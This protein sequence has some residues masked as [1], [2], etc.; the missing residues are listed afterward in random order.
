MTI[1]R[2]VLNRAGVFNFWFY[3][4][5]VFELSDG[6]LIFRGANGSGKSV[7]MQS[8]LPLVLDGDKRPSRLDP[9]GSRDRK[10]EYY[11]L[12]EMESGINDRTGYLYLEFIQPDSGK[13]V[14]IGIGLRARRGAAQV[15]FWGFAVTDQRRIGKDL[16]LYDTDL[17]EK[18][19]KKVPLDRTELEAV[20]GEGG[21]VVREQGEYRQLVNQLLFGFED[22]EAYKDLL[23]LL[24]Q[25]RSPKLSKEF[26]PSTIYGILNEAL[27]PL[28]EEDLRPLSEVLE[29]MDEIGDRL[30]ELRLHRAE[31][32]KLEATYN[33][34]NELRLYELSAR[35]TDDAR[36]R[37]EK[38]LGVREQENEW[39][40]LKG[41]VEQTNSLLSNSKQELT[42]KET[43]ADYLNRSE[44]MEKQQ[45]LQTVEERLNEAQNEI[46]RSDSRLK[47]NEEEIGRK[48]KR[49]KDAQEQ[50][51][52][53]QR[54]QDA[55]RNELESLSKEMEFKDHFIYE[56]QWLDD[57][58]PEDERLWN[59]WKRDVADY[60]LRLKEVHVL[61]VRERESAAR[62][63]EVEENMSAA[64]EK[65]D[66]VERDMQAKEEA[67][68]QTIL[69]QEDALLAWFK[70]LQ[71]L[72]LSE[73]AWR[74]MIHRLHQYP[75]LDYDE[76]AAPV[77]E[78]WENA[79]SAATTKRLQVEHERKLLTEDRDQ[80]KA[81]W[82]EWKRY[83]EPEPERTEAR[84]RS[85]RRRKEVAGESC[86]GAPLYTC[87]EFR[88]HVDEAIKAILESV[89]QR[90]G[91]LDAWISPTA[92]SV[93]EQ[94]EEMWLNPAPV[95]FGHTLVDYLE[96]VVPEGSGLTIQQIEDILR[97]V[98]IGD[99][100][101]GG[102]YINEHGR[103]VLGPLTGQ[104]ASKPRAEWIGVETRK[105]TRLAE[106]QR[107]EE[108]IAE[109]ER[110][111]AGLNESWAALVY[112]IEQ[113][114]L[115]RDALPS[116]E[117]LRA[118]EKA[119]RHAHAELEHARQV[120][121]NLSEKY[122]DAVRQWRELQRSLLESTAEWTRLKKEK[123]FQEAL[124]C[125]QEYE[126][127]GLELKSSFTISGRIQMEAQLLL[128]EI[129]LLTERAQ[130]EEENLQQF[131]LREREFIAAVE[132]L[133]ALVQ[134][135]GAL[136]I[137]RQLQQLKKECNELKQTIEQCNTQLRRLDAELGASAER[138]TQRKSALD[139][140]EEKLR[141]SV[142]RLQR[143]WKWKLVELTSDPSLQSV[144]METH[145]VVIRTAHTVRGLY[146]ARYDSRRKEQVMTHL[147]E[148]FALAKNA[149]LEY[150]LEQ[151]Y[152]EE[153][154][155][156][157]IESLRDRNQP[158]TPYM[159]LRELTRMEEEQGLLIDEKDK[160][161]YEQILIHS[162]GRAIKDKI[163][164]AE[165]W[166][167]IMNRFMEERKT[168]SGLILSLEWTPRAARNERELD[169]EKL[170]RL[171]R[172]DPS[173]LLDE[174]L[175]QMVEHFRSRIRWAK[176]D[177]EEGDS[178]RK[179]IQEL[180]DYRGWFTFTLYYR[181]GSQPRRE[182]TDSRFNVLSGGEKAMAMYIP[183]FA[184]TDSRY[185]DSRETA[186][187]MIS[188]DE[189][190]AGVDDENMR[191]MFGLLT[192]MK[193][194]YMMTSQV[195]WGCYD[196]V[197]SLSIYEIYRPLD[198]DFVTLIPYYWNG[199][200]RKMLDDGEWSTIKEVA[201]SK[202]E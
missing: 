3:T 24:I 21:K 151:R 59:S 186:P 25:L 97:T 85:R 135:M 165:Q 56:R 50:L 109:I 10:I 18:Q 30:E 92:M 96:P 146:R 160:E 7:T 161:L 71:W 118:A 129:D 190:F 55:L 79:L 148:T 201:A 78:A 41:E 17:F 173:T 137:H 134:E 114:K 167:A 90:S 101:E 94:E 187:R 70:R 156:I 1:Q 122:K 81:Q 83:R 177:A 82:E 60:R 112:H 95:W 105:Q 13:V 171:L 184:A 197:P 5:E 179:W 108:A 62:A 130:I 63:R 37:E 103:F 121:A 169:T 48:E 53:H 168:S 15:G 44:A 51:E 91:L 102:A 141:K 8:F 6:K 175:A 143:E 154:D 99:E 164:R 11:L 23:E 74:A 87:C 119:L 29:D 98:Q 158:W 194:D 47:A 19:G 28:S 9:F 4:D 68:G 150:S 202:Q 93:M 22:I 2:S 69:L 20:I 73:D 180:L 139:E 152:D 100:T 110:Q 123:D 176:D 189:A 170:V 46:R 57:G 117:E 193:F 77:K 89:L 27:P 128:E 185:K 188:L 198:V 106:M 86:F 126:G 43:K 178:L 31:A 181:K 127:N 116:D 200:Q 26:K 39:N 159:L 32:Q 192:D 72:P 61:S 16:F 75:R 80:F 145:S 191:D 125:L 33:Q 64:R 162:V 136:D 36:E 144:N 35:I 132:T 147:Q 140:C 52:R 174:E 133:S 58:Q 183:L 84:S 38:E 76:I 157:F 88:P 14:T 42:E 155:R 115:E 163:N 131:R 34:Y 65:R 45:E 49:A 40:K 196:T 113:V 138:L 111:I 166:V 172:K 107:L 142:E 12:G 67:L 124:E 149:L 66:K 54:E 153:G 182:L 104:I 199:Y 120:E 195:L